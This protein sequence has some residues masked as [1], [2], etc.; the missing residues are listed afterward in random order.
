MLRGIKIDP[1]PFIIFC[2]I[3]VGGAA[4]RR[5]PVFTRVCYWN[6]LLNWL[7]FLETKKISSYLNKIYT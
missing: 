6:Y 5:F 3:L 4:I 1:I 2:K 7:L